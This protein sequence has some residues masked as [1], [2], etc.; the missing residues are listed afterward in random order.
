[1]SA[2][3]SVTSGKPNGSESISNLRSLSRTQFNEG[4][5]PIEI[6]A[7]FSFV[8]MS[9]GTSATLGTEGANYYA[10]TLAYDDQGRL[11][12]TV[13]ADGTIYRTVRDG[14]DRVISQWVGDDDT[15]T[16]GGWSPSNPAG[17]IRTALYA[18]D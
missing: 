7:Y 1:M 16:T 10:T 12:R 18:Y 4:G 15:P 5:Q 17:M 9:Y 6:D 8:S 2:T 14:Q 3:P 13:R 11:S